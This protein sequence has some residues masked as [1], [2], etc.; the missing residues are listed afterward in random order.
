[1]NKTIRA[2]ININSVRNKFYSYIDQVNGNADLVLV[3]ETKNDHNFPN[4]QFLI[5]GYEIPYRFCKNS[6]GCGIMLCIK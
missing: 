5:S 4:E 3:P 6:P 1:M 2:Y